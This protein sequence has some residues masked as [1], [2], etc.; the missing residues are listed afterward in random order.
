MKKVVIVGGGKGC[1]A[2]LPIIKELG[3]KVV[4]IADINPKAPAFRLAKRLH[5]KTAKD[6][7]RFLEKDIDFVIDVTGTRHVIKEIRKA[8][9]ERTDIITGLTAKLLWNAVEERKEKEEQARMLFDTGMLLSSKKSLQ[10][11]LKAVLKNAMKLT[12]MPSGSLVLYDEKSETFNLVVSFGF[13]KQFSSV[14]S[15]RLRPRGVTSRIVLSKKPLVVENT[16]KEKDFDNPVMLKEGIASLIATPLVLDEKIIGIIYADD[17]KERKFSSRDIDIMRIY[18]E[19][20]AIAIVKAKLLENQ[21]ELATTDE[22]TGIYNYRYFRERLSEET[23]RAERYEYALS[24]IMFDIDFFKNYNDMYGH[25]KGDAVLK[26]IASVVAENIR[27]TDIFARY[28]GEEFV[29]VLP[30]T[31][32]RKALTIA[33]RS[34]KMIEKTKFFGMRKMPLHY[35]TISC[36]IASLPCKDIIVC[37]DYALYKAK[38]LGRNRCFVYKERA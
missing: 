35:I 12:R 37:A 20:A 26:K 4:G 27:K 19:Q 24:L 28:G 13:S 23:R 14:S 32:R 25:R 3:L 10:E 29:I 33:E 7:R 38:Q 9:S 1:M 17:F 22:L 18:A 31:S 11:T 34:R 15:W 6:F 21:K 8:K 16:K 36:G 2:L 5:I 30:E